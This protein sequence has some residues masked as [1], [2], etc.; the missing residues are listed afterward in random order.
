MIILDI[1]PV[2][3]LI[4][5]EVFD[6]EGNKIGKVV[7]L[8]RKD[9]DNDYKSIIV[10]KHFFSKPLSIPKRDID[11]IEKNIILNTSYGD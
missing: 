7:D 8:D 3:M 11:V 4:G 9:Y 1:D 5:K 6:D 2:I 10:K